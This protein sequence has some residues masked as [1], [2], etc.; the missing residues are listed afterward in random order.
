[1]TGKMTGEGTGKMIGTDGKGYEGRRDEKAQECV[2]IKLGVCQ[3]PAM[4][5]SLTFGLLKSNIATIILRSPLFSFTA[6]CLVSLPLKKYT[7]AINCS[8]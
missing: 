7:E 5:I 4:S 8:I 6:S 3:A 2:D 1:M